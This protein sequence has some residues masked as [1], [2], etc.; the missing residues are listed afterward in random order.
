M[1]Y[2]ISRTISLTQLS[3]L[4]PGAKPPKRAHSAYVFFSLDWRERIQTENP[5]AGFG[6]W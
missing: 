5:N 1:F 3:L 6:E 2:R 4:E